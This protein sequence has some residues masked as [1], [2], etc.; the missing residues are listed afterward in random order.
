MGKHA[1]FVE[2]FDLAVAGGGVCRTGRIAL[3]RRC[4]RAPIHASLIP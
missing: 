3:I 4:D 1:G 2:R